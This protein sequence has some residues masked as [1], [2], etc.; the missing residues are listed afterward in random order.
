[1]SKTRPCRRFP[2]TTGNVA[3]YGS[4]V[5]ALSPRPGKRRS[6]YV[7]SGHI[8]FPTGTLLQEPGG[9]GPRAEGRILEQFGEIPC[10]GS[11]P[12]ARDPELVERATHPVDRQSTVG[13]PGDHLGQEGVGSHGNP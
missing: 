13:G 2:R 7:H 8:M 1:A 11:D 9:V 10:G 3:R 5:R 12:V 4:R 6:S